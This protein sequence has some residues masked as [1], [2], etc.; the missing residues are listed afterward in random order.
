M[1]GAVTGRA[2]TQVGMVVQ[3]GSGQ[4]M[5][6]S[7]LANNTAM[8]LTG[9]TTYYID[10][11]GKDMSN[12]P[13]TPMFD[14]S[15]MY[16]GERIRCISNSAVGS[17]GAGM[18][19]MGGGGVMGTANASECDLVQQGFTGTL[20]NYT[21]SGGQATFTLTLAANSYFAI[22]TG[23]TATTVH[24]QPET[25]LVG[26]TSIANVQFVQ[27]RGLMFDSSGASLIWWSAGSRT[28]SGK[29]RAQAHAGM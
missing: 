10:K 19:G 7:F 23:T 6:S 21:S 26:L 29:K 12:L 14:A 17:G 8:N 27:V 28:R 5:M 3:N 24:Q 18:G 11:D 25:Q 20:S 4:G 15:H 22:M 9:S 13:F 1:I 16:P 2:A